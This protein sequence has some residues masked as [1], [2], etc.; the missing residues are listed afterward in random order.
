MDPAIVQITVIVT[1]K[2]DENSFGRKGQGSFSTAIGEGLAGPKKRPNR[3]D[4][5]RE[6]R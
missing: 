3:P 5:E 1:A 4:F 6:G 2:N